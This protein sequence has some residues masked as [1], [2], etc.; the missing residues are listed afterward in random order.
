M[1]W[2]EFSRVE[3]ASSDMVTFGS[4]WRFDKSL[5]DADVVILVG[6]D[7][8]CCR[9]RDVYI[10]QADETDGLQNIAQEQVCFHH[11]VMIPRSP[12]ACGV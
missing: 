11:L 4:S 10:Y 3:S 7:A 12:R 9:S 2:R 6:E 8:R 5:K 1:L